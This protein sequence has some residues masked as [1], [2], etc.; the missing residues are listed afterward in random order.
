MTGIEALRDQAKAARQAQPTLAAATT[1]LKNEALREMAR[2]L[3]SH[4]SFL[5]EANAQDII[6]RLKLVGDNTGQLLTLD[7]ELATRVY[8]NPFPTDA[9]LGGTAIA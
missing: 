7:N 8:V 4:Q 6:D 1:E 2:M 9:K 5:L 3:L